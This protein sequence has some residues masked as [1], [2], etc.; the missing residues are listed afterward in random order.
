MLPLLTSLSTSILPLC[1]SIILCVIVSPRPVPH[2]FVVKNAVLTARSFS[3]ERLDAIFHHLLAAD[4][5]VKTGRLDPTLALDLLV[6]E[7]TAG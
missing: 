7:I 3:N 6:V 4:L 5:A 2:P 1:F